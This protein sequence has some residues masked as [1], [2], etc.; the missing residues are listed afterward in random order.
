MKFYSFL[1][2][3]I[4]WDINLFSLDVM[5]FYGY[6]FFDNILFF[7]LVIICFDFMY[8]VEYIKGINFCVY[9]LCVCRE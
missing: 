9:C 8:I 6:I 7:M 1:Y 2:C 4:V 5:I 3:S